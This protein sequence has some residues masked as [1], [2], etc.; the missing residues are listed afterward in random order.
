MSTLTLDDVK[1]A[2]DIFD[3]AYQL[4]LKRVALIKFKLKRSPELKV[5]KSVQKYENELD[6]LSKDSV[7]CDLWNDF[8][9]VELGGELREKTMEDRDFIHHCRGLLEGSHKILQYAN[10]FT[11]E[12]SVD[13]VKL[14]KIVSEKLVDEITGWK[15]QAIAMT[16]MDFWAFDFCIA[17]IHC[18]IEKC[19]AVLELTHYQ[20]NVTVEWKLFHSWWETIEINQSSAQ[21]LHC[22]HLQ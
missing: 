14:L 5:F 8:T 15:S 20:Q 17:E 10:P 3:N 6:T 9:C 16:K 1:Q 12:I 11:S 22:Q 7:I 21:Q 19:Q 2:N 18:V 13:D 4:F